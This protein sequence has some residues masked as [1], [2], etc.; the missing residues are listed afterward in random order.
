MGTRTKARCQC[1]YASSDILIGGGEMNFQYTQYY[2]CLCMDC[3]DVVQVNLK[4]ML[5]C[6]KCTGA[7]IIPYDDERLRGEYKEPEIRT[8]QY[9]DVSNGIYYCPKCKEMTLKF[10]RGIFMWD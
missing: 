10:L 8:T 4:G 5:N 2:P 1:G 9:H 7:N 6:P 3:E